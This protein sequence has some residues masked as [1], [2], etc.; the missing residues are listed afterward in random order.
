MNILIVDDDVYS[1]L[2]LTNL[3]QHDHMLRIASNGQ[4]A[5][6][7]FNEGRYDVVVTDISMPKMNGIE[8]LKAIRDVDTDLPVIIVSGHGTAANMTEAGQYGVSAFYTKPLDVGRFM[9]MLFTLEAKT[10]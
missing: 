2:A 8:L 7:L 5:L 1:V 3:L 6:A 4:D 10:V 9:D